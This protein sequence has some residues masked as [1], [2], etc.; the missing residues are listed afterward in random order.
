MLFKLT[1]YPEDYQFL[2]WEIMDVSCVVLYFVFKGRNAWQNTWVQ[3]YSPDCFYLTLEAAKAY[4]EKNRTN[5]TRFYIIQTPALALHTAGATFLITQVN[6]ETPLSCY[7]FITSN[8]TQDRSALIKSLKRCSL[9][10]G[11]T[12]GRA[13][14]S[15]SESGGFLR[16]PLA[17]GEKII[18]LSFPIFSSP[19]DR[20]VTDDLKSLRSTSTGPRYYLTWQDYTIHRKATAILR[21][22][23]YIDEF[24]KLFKLNKKEINP[25]SLDR[26]P[27]Y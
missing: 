17:Q 1:S 8:S 6:T 12:V 15:L 27:L 22:K 23:K 9:Y 4:S 24:S 7:E 10:T 21:I 3:K 13:I 14:K 16:S 26:H 18:H 20:C 5:G 2:N 25:L 19:F 11:A